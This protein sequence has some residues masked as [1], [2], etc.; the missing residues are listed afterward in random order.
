MK[1]LTLQGKAKQVQAKSGPVWLALLLLHVDTRLS[2]GRQEIQMRPAVPLWIA[3]A[4][5]ERG[6]LPLTGPLARPSPSGPNPNI[7][8]RLHFFTA[9]QA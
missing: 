2:N 3:V 6:R 9:H 1:S 4:R 7:S 5:G 8:I